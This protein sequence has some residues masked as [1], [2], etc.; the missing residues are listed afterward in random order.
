VSRVSVQASVRAL[1]HFGGASTVIFVSVVT[2][3]GGDGYSDLA[4][5]SYL[6]FSFIHF[7]V[8]LCLAK[9]GTFLVTRVHQVL[10]LG[11]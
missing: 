2:A 1:P 5:H 6:S 8:L 9:A 10:P 11:L 3:I 4:K 7:L